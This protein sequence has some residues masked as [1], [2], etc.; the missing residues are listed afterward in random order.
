MGFIDFAIDRL[1]LKGGA[2]GPLNAVV[3]GKTKRY[4]NTQTT[5]GQSIAYSQC[6]AV[7]SAI[8]KRALAQSNLRIW[9]LDDRSRAIMNP[10][11]KADMEMLAKMNEAQDFRQ[12]TH[13]LTVFLLT[14]GKAFVYKHKL[15][16]TDRHYYYVVPNSLVTPAY[17]SVK[18]E[19]DRLYRPKVTKWQVTLPGG[20]MEIAADKME[21]FWDKHAPI[22]PMNPERVSRLAPMSWVVSTLITIEETMQQ[23]MAD[24]GARGI[25]G[26]G[27]KDVDMLTAPFLNEEMADIQDKLKKYGSLSDQW[28]YIVTKG[29]STYTPMLPPVDDLKMPEIYNHNKV[30]LYDAYGIPAAFTVRETRF[31]ALPEAKLMFYTDTVIPEGVDIVNSILEMVGVPKRDWTYAPDWSHLDIYQDALAKKGVALQTASQGLNSLVQSEIITKREAK[32]ILDSFLPE[33]L[34]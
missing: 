28:K 6:S 24:G 25:I 9:A 3:G 22:D 32:D 30:E 31:K 7:R 16:G 4:V 13:M 26:L 1:M 19:L 29:A 10:T 5:H 34:Q 33:T 21:V 23:F 12:F 2:M 20:V 27:A 14:Y 17:Q 18:N 8:N 11:V 15:Y